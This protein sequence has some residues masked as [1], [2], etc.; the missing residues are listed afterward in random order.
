MT[1]SPDNEADPTIKLGVERLVYE[2]PWIDL[3]YDDI[4]HPNGKA[5]NYAWVQSHSGNGAVMTIPV[6]PS[7]KFLLIKV[8]HHPF[9]RYLWEFPAGVMEDGESPEEA[10]RRDWHRTHQSGTTRITNSD[11]WICWIRV[12]FARRGNTRDNS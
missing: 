5:G 12:S 1:E 2:T 7:G 11:C 6:T 10:G 3:Y 8:Y 4:T 9:K